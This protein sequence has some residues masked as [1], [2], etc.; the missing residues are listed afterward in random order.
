MKDM[1]I[2]L[3]E[4]RELICG[5]TPPVGSERLP[6]VAC[7]GRVLAEDFTA[8]MDQP[9]FPRSA[10]DGYAV[11]SEDTVGAC[12]IQPVCLEV[13]SKVCAGDMA[14]V[15]LSP[16]KAVRIMTGGVI[17]K[18]A[19]CVIRQE[20]TDY[21]EEMVRIYREA[22]PWMNY[23]RKGEDFSKGELLAE[24]G[25]T[26]D[27]YTVAVAAAAGRDALC[28]CR[29]IK[30]AVITT[31]DEL[32]MPGETLGDGKIYD[33]NM[34]Y[35]HSRLIQSGCV[36]SG[37]YAAGD[38][39]E[40]ICKTVMRAKE[41]SNLVITTGGVSVGQKDL[42]PQA[43]EQMGADILFH[44]I[45]IKPGMPTMFSML[46]GVPVLSLSGNP[47]SASAIFEL[48]AQPLFAKMQGKKGSVL[49]KRTAVLQNDYNK[50]SPARRILRGIY[51]GSGVH[52]PAEQSN[53]QMKA[54]IGSNCLVDIPAYS[55]RLKA[56]ERVQ[57][58]M[59]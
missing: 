17:P 33:S 8:L 51:D 4:A 56:G 47:Y 55:D 37:I 35:L 46:Q 24:A 16:G 3:E 45:A 29:R 49:A 54:G 42:I 38:D 36:A 22:V 6:L 18:G 28:V 48:L 19:D 1:E 59:V 14:S 25:N 20:D 57:I 5:A 11:R 53:G 30:A 50:K 7:I 21:G 44:G 31:G 52:V 40:Q 43:M 15:A 41:T 9:P 12:G 23:C 26:V 58:I 10:M 2:T 32:C 13:E 39:L 27:A 34:A